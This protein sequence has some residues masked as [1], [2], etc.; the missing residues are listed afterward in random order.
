MDSEPSLISPATQKEIISQLSDKLKAGYVFPDVAE[1]ICLHLQQTLAEGE[2]DG[3]TDGNLFALALTMQLQ[4]VNHDEHLWVRWQ[5]QPLPLGESP[6]RNDPAWQEQQQAK[7]RAENYGLH[8]LE[9]LPG[10]VGYLD[11]HY[12]HKPAWAGDTVVAAMRF[13]SESDALILD[14]RQC[15]GG[16]PGTVALV[17]TYLFNEEP[18]LLTS[19]YWRDEDRTQ[20]YWTLPYVPGKRLSD[21]PL[22]VLISKNTFSAGEMAASALQS[23][24]RATLIGEQTD[25]GVNPGT[26]FRLHPHFEAFIPIGCTIDPL[27]GTHKESAG[28]TPDITASPEESFDMAYKFALQSILAEIEKIYQAAYDCHKYEIKKALH[29]LKQ[30]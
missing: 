17:C 5:E 4:E 12:F 19:I 27:T 25:G 14:L 20:Q 16:Y 22:Y 28:V 18:I 8:K 29:D 1:Q 13:L 30:R 11:I 7:A 9:K 24:P 6:L 3:L 21:I 10:N 26:S 2:Y 15:K 23:H